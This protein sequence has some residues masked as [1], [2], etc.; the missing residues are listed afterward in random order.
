MVDAGQ[1]GSYT[2]KISYLKSLLFNLLGFF[3]F[4]FLCVAANY[5]AAQIN[6][7]CGPFSA[8]YCADAVQKVGFPLVFAEIGGGPMPPGAT[9]PPASVAALL[10]DVSLGLIGSAVAG[11]TCQYYFGRSRVGDQTTKQE[12][13]L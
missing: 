5:I 3:G 6:T 11:A 7:N 2:L 9:R 10:F 12:S 8:W 1:K 4:L 13:S